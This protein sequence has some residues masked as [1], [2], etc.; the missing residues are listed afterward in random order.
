MAWNDPGRNR[1]PWGN[2]PDKGTADLDEALRNLQRK[3]SQ[4]FGGDGGNGDTGFQ[5]LTAMKHEELPFFCGGQELR[6]RS[7]RDKAQ[8]TRLRLFA[9]KIPCLPL[10]PHHSRAAWQPRAAHR[11]SNLFA[12]ARKSGRPTMSLY[13]ENV[14]RSCSAA[15]PPSSFA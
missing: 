3:L 4:M 2:R 10:L 15:L 6:G 5:D 14:T 9:L 7:Q 12:V 8:R 11:V 13:C 1:N